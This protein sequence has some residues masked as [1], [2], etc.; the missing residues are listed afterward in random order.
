MADKQT[1]LMRQYWSVKKK[2][3]DTVLLFRLGDFFETFEEDARIASRV[4]GLT[5]TK[6]NNGSAE[7][8]PLAGFPHHQ[9]DNYLPKLVRAGYRVAVCEQLEDPKQARG[10]VRRDVVEVVTPGVAFNDKLLDAKRNNYLA[11][12]A[13]EQAR[14]GVIVGLACVDV[15]TG[16]FLTTEVSLPHLGELLETLQPSEILIS[17]AVL[18]SGIFANAASIRSPA[19]TSASAS[20]DTF[21]STL[22]DALLAAFQM[23]SF[24][25]TIT[26]ME[27]WMLE[28]TFARDVLLRHFNTHTL[29]G[30]GIE[31]F[32][33]GVAA[34]GAALQYVSDTQRGQ[35]PHLQ[36]ISML[37][38]AD[39][40]TLDVATKRNLEITLSMNS[41]AQNSRQGTLIGILDKTQTAMGGRLFVRWITRPLRRL[42]AL[43][44]RQ[45]AVAAF[46]KS[47]A[48]RA[49][50]RKELASIGDM[51]RL[52]AKISTGRATPRDVVAL[53]STLVHLPRVRK[54]TADVAQKQRCELLMELAER[55]Q[56]MEE[57]VDVLH[58]ALTDE[59]P[60]ALG[61]GGV[62][63]EGYSAALDEIRNTMYSSKQWIADFQEQERL[64]SGIN[65]LKVGFNN[66]FGYY[67]EITNAHK[68]RVPANYERRQTLANAE[69]Y[70][71]A[72][73]KQM[74]Q[75]ILSA[76]E[77]IAEVERELFSALRDTIIAQAEHIQTNASVLATL[78]CLQ[79]LA[80]A[81]RE[82]NYC[83]PLLEESGRLEIFDG[84]H[85]VVERL[86]PL[87]EQY[88]P[89]STYLDPQSEQ[90]HIITGPNM[91]GKSSYL[92]QVGLITLLA[93]IGA[94][95]PAK[96]ATIGLVD[97]IFTRVGA[98][99]N[100]TAGES[101]FLVE[102]QEAANIL[103][104][105]TAQSLVLL[106]E[107]GRGT[108]TYDGI[109]IAWAIAEYLHDRVG[110]KTLFAT[111]YH[112][113]TEIAAS[114]ARIR[115]YRA[116]VQ[117]I[118]TSSV[119]AAPQIVFTR[120][121][122]PGT[123]DHSFGIHVAEM[124]GL[125]GDV[126]ERARSIMRSL[127]RARSE[128]DSSVVSSARFQ[129]E[130]LRS[131]LSA[132]VVDDS[133]SQFSLFE[134]RDDALREKIRRLDL[135][136]IT[137]L[138]ALQ[139]LAELQQTVKG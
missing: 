130:T 8:T 139:I 124:A 68:S 81:A 88:V 39:F 67:I 134:I 113:L 132:Q 62:F 82:Y 86:L 18:P 29:K 9:L 133:M 129:H 84:R 16:E 14:Q 50:F 69:R 80:Q 102:M 128:H 120:R 85:P 119:S 93:H 91:S 122:V 73:L 28:E 66:V 11:A 6:R 64:A 99:D 52:M 63:R 125:P 117:E 22:T 15:S 87:G 110:A 56:M 59:P 103:N 3:P 10:I 136:T 70:T 65:S 79:A 116:E 20:A 19:G 35:L 7:E 123:A 58:R 131:V 27:P 12:L 115:N 53:R 31:E 41:T 101:T 98:Q 45:N 107:V 1:P 13:V 111:H 25:P 89:N 72:V 77:R 43:Q 76:E 121:I 83:C 48:L 126:V 92:R 42:D 44:R 33:A 137:P 30:F 60:A 114:H 127:E 46:F 5:L 47:D 23:L 57:L 78:D 21:G 104:N 40:M 105:A 71:T 109:S 54:L 96:Q 4:C 108:A 61:G 34:A 26:R 97:R 100:I 135:N 17:K 2:Y 49:E 138:Q 55:L 112:E 38:S 74:E 94:F 75:R 118:A 95:V 36:R 24:Q 32:H 37:N 106:D 90:L 51:E